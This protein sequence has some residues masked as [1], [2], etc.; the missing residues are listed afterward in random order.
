MHLNGM[1]SAKTVNKS[2]RLEEDRK[3][4]TIESS[5]CYKWLPQFQFL[6]N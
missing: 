4:N 1:P 6:I 2:W 5:A 3:P